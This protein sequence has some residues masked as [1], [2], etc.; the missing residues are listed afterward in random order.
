[1]FTV[2]FEVDHAG[3]RA[4]MRDCASRPEYAFDARSS[5]D[6]LAAFNAISRTVTKL[7]IAG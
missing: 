5:A 1:M 4:L 7:R 3:T 6:L 2:A